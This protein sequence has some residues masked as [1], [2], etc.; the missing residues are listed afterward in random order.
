MNSASSQRLPLDPVEED[1]LVCAPEVQLGLFPESPGRGRRAGTRRPR[2]RGSRCRTPSRRSPPPSTRKP[3]EPGSEPGSSL[4]DRLDRLHRLELEF[5]AA[6]S[7]PR[8]SPNG[9]STARRCLLGEGMDDEDR[10]PGQSIGPGVLV[11]VGLQV[12]E[13]D[14]DRALEGLREQLFAGEPR[15]ENV[16]GAHVF[17]HLDAEAVKQHRFGREEPGVPPHRAERLRL[18]P[19]RRGLAPRT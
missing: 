5:L 15:A 1:H 8:R 19:E 4:R 18:P 12:S 10:S 9:G 17:Q 7:R 16:D 6:S 14:S 2:S 13:P 3:L 11:V